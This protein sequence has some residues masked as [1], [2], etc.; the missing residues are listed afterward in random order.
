[1]D[2]KTENIKGAIFD[3]DGTLLDSMS[4]WE[5]VGEKY[6]LSCG[7][8]PFENIGEVLKTMSLFQAAEY[9]QK[10]YKIKQTTEEIIQGIDGSLTVEYRKKYLQVL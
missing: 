9:F 7:I 10:E 2:F 4:I 5:D 1:M 6:L 8:I 3:L